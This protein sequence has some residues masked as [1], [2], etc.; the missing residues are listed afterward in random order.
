MSRR[1]YD[2]SDWLHHVHTETLLAKYEL[3]LKAAYK[4]LLKVCSESHDAEV[5]GA[6]ERHGS[7]D[8]T[9]RMLKGQQWAKERND[10]E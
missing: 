2:F 8:A 10:D 6:F 9:V 1:E 3:Q 4:D 7:L 5:R